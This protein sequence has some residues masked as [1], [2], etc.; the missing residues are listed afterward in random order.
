ME[1][2]ARIEKSFGDFTLFADFEV[3]GDRIGIFGRSGSGKSTLVGLLAGLDQPD[4]GE[5]F[6]DGECVF[7]SS[8]GI[9]VPAHRRRVG[10][11]FQ[12]PAL[13]PHLSV[14][15]NLLY[16]FRRCAAPHRR[17]DDL[18]LVETSLKLEGLL[19]RG[20]NNL[21]GGEKQRVALGRAVLA[22][23]RL[24]VM[25]EPLSALDDDLKFQII[26]YIRSVS[27]EFHIPY[28]FIS[29]SL[30]EMRLLT[31]EV[32]VL[33][34]GQVERQTSTEMLARELMGTG[35]AGYMNA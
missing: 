3:M 13:F 11:V 32:I 33:E 6:L 10:M 8:K 2:R 9:N 7:S 30:T 1:I 25:D 18:E 29:H 16:G 34:G 19:K 12:Q 28:L 15:A 21:S 4:R 23:P 22:N 35:L 24:L 5:I 27:E 20:V 14:K 17:L 26:P 31:D